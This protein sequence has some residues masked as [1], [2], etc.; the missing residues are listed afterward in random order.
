MIK[1]SMQAIR[2]AITRDVTHLSST[3]TNMTQQCHHQ[4]DSTLTTRHGQHRLGSAIASIAR[5]RRHQ[6]KQHMPIC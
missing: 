2:E 6:A 4:H 5:Q 3:I 1:T